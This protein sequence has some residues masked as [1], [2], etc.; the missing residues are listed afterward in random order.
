MQNLTFDYLNLR[1]FKLEHMRISRL[2]LSYN[3]RSRRALLV[4]CSRSMLLM[5][6]LTQSGP[7][8]DFRI[9]CRRPLPPLYFMGRK[10]YW[11]K[12]DSSPT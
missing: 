2:Q 3:A 4:S 5:E 10:Q 12:P 11:A 6:V 1:V 8:L 7:M 9:K